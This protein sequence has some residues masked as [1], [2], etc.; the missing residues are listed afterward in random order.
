LPFQGPLGAV[1][2]GRSN[3]KLVFNQGIEQDAESDVHILIAGN[4]DGICMVEGNCELLSEDEMVELF[5]SAHEEIKR[6]IAWQEEIVR[7][8]G[9]EKI[10]LKRS[11]DWAGWQ[12]KAVEWVSSSGV[13]AALFKPTKQEQGAQLEEAKQKFHEQFGEQ[14]EAEGVSHSIMNYMFDSALKEVLPDLIVEKGHRFDGRTMDTVRP[15]SSEIGLLPEVHGSAVFQ[16]GQTQ[17]LASITLG[18]AQ[19]A[20]KVEKLVEGVQE[21]SFM[22]HYNFPPFSVG[23][24]RPVRSVGRREIGHGYL[25][26]NS[27]NKVVPSQEDFPYTIRSVVDI[28]ECN[29]SSSMATVCAST[30]AMMDA[31]VPLKEMVAGIAMGLIQDSS[32]K[33]HVLTDLTGKEDALGLM[34][35]KVTGSENGIRAIQ[36][37]IKAKEGL[38]R[39]LLVTALGR[40]RQAREHILVEMRKTIDTPRG[41]IAEHAPKVTQFSIDTDKIGVVI[42]PSGKVIKEIIAQTETQIDIQD[43]GTVRIYGKD[44]SA[45]KRAEQWIRVL[46]GD[47]AD[48][49]IFNGVIKRFA[50][51]GIF[52]ELVPGKD[53]LLHV[54][55]I[56]KDKQ[57]N[58]SQLYRVNDVLRV[59]VVSSDPESGRIKLW[60]QE[61]APA[62]D[63]D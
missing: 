22:V 26:E 53:G 6:Q 24:V 3:G 32:G 63:R 27:F 44:S 1:Y 48:G 8:C 40:A 54:S 49:A 31:G 18:T 62:G 57:K 61:L 38:S 2:V 33:Y 14:A 10:T 43:D 19:D 41:A 9:K 45:A 42:G 15:I 39:D 20:Q 58:L 7:E 13:G 36:M 11:F 25:A 30:L 46:V 59:K 56:A 55:S 60:A 16:R 47:I 23:E 5:F 52:V 4:R 28:L 29:G 35:F 21:R 17:A 51:F 50:E 37:D 12:S 34:D